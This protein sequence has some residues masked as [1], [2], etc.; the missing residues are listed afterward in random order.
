MFL[1]GAS[2]QPPGS[3]LLAFTPEQL[4]WH[5]LSGSPPHHPTAH[6]YGSLH[7][8]P[9]GSLHFMLPA[10]PA[11]L[12]LWH[13]S[14]AVQLVRSASFACE[15][16]QHQLFAQ[17][18]RTAEWQGWHAKDTD[19]QAGPPH[20]GQWTCYSI[21][22]PHQRTGWRR[23]RFRGRASACNSLDRRMI[24]CLCPRICW[25]E[26]C[27]RSRWR[28]SSPQPSRGSAHQ[29]AA[30][31]MLGDVAAGGARSRLASADQIFV[32]LTGTSRQLPTLHVPSHSPVLQAVGCEVQ[33]ALA[34]SM[35]CLASVGP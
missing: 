23:C 32:A 17:C 7:A 10:A 29:V 12:P 21:L 2:T 16:N 15:V 5:V 6:S 34:A 20:R 4:A 35:H 31:C 1:P 33:S 22:V 28:R 8:A 26:C 14:L 11:H 25:S 3:V 30:I 13:W 18:S 19:I 24:R 27:R 9:V